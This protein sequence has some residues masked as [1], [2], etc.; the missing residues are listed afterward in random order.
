[1]DLR[2]LSLK[3]LQLNEFFV[4][5]SLINARILLKQ[6]DEDYFKYKNLVELQALD[7]LDRLAL[8]DMLLLHRESMYR[9]G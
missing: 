3:H 6:Y 9:L 2:F 7:Y 1:M 4:I 8:H 5:F